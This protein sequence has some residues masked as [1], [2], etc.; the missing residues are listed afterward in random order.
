MVKKRSLLVIMLNIVSLLFSGEV[1]AKEKN[2]A[3]M[4]K[5][6]SSPVLFAGDEHTAYR[7]PVIMYDHHVFYLFFTLVETESDGRIYSYV[8]YSK[9]RDLVKWSK[10]RKLTVKDQNLNYSSPGNVIR[11]NNE[12]ILCFQTYPRPDY[13]CYQKIRYGDDT[14]RLFIMRSKDL[15]KWSSP[16]LL[17]V[18]G[19]DILC[20]DMGRM[21]D[22]YLMQD[23]EDSTKYWCFYKQNGVS[24]SYSYDLKSWKYFGHTSG[25]EN[26]SLLIENNEYVLFHSPGNGI[27]I[28]RS[29]DLM[30]WKDWGELITLGQKQWKWAQGRITAGAVIDLRDQLNIKAYVMFF[31]G[32]GPLSET[33][34]DF[35]KN[36]SIG[37]AWSDDLIHW[38][39]PE[40][41][42]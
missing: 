15:K 11:F 26:S 29:S 38:N 4:L 10:V 3:N 18:K 42:R 5:K 22:P 12:W 32:S 19:E 39:W 2:D 21:I 24:L 14:A 23:K 7:D 30:H 27:G 6:I 37:I 17:K 8:A 41:G 31:H 1:Y 13:T 36:S 33:E 25:G 35:D 9:S 16:E 28:K 34:G 20:K 40:D